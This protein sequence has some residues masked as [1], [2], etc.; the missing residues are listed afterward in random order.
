MAVTARVTK[1]PRIPENITV[2]EVRQPATFARLPLQCSCQRASC[3]VEIARFPPQCGGVD[4]G[5]E[6]KTQLAPI[7]RKPL[8]GR[9]IH[10]R[11]RHRVE[12]ARPIQFA[13]LYSTPAPRALLGTARH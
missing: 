11:R 4:E 3:D 10:S 8:Q 1:A 9:T 5:T 6:A 13:P 7:L 2:T 12:R